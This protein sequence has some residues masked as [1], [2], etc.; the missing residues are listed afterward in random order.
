MLDCPSLETLI[1]ARCRRLQLVGGFVHGLNVPRLVTLNVNACRDVSDEG[2][3]LLVDKLRHLRHL[4]VGGCIRLTRLKVDFR[5]Q[6]GC[7]LDAYGCGRLGHVEI[8]GS[9]GLIKLVTAG[10]CGADGVRVI[11]L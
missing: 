2:L 4:N 8:R 5:Q 3:N 10:C 6:P 1:A 9:A 7:T 11:K